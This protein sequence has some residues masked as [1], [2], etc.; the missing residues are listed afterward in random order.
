MS[1]VNII[2]NNIFILY[3]INMVISYPNNIQTTFVIAKGTKSIHGPLLP[4]TSIWCK[5]SENTIVSSSRGIS[6]IQMKDLQIPEP[7]E[8][9]GRYITIKR[10]TKRLRL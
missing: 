6:K 5:S 4:Q 8:I 1:F 10:G 7:V 3:G 2:F 9:K